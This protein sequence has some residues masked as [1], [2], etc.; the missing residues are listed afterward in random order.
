VEY[1]KYAKTQKRKKKTLKETKRR[2]AGI[3]N[4]KM[5]S[6]ENFELIKRETS[7]N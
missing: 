6:S 7:A 3:P 2:R 5:R 4:R 1:K